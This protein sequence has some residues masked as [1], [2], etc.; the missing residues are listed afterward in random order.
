[1]AIISKVKAI[2]KMH[3]LLCTSRETQSLVD[4]ELQW[5]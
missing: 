4:W 5:K 3:F 1:M 2:V